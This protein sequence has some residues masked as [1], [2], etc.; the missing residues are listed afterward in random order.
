MDLR[1][2]EIVL[3]RTADEAI[4][5]LVEEAEKLEV[6]QEPALDGQRLVRIVTEAGD[7]E[8]LLDRIERRFGQYEG[9]R[10]VILKVEATLPRPA[11]RKE[12]ERIP[13]KVGRR[14]KRVS[15]EE[16]LASLTPGMRISRRFVAMIVLSAIVAAVGLIEDNV[17]V[18]I[19]AMVIAPLLGPNMALALA[20]TLGDLE[21][22]RR[23]V[24]TNVVGVLIAFAFSLGL[25]LVVT[26]SF[27]TA[28]IHARTAP[29]WTAAVVALAAG[30]AG[31]LAFTA[32]VPASLVGVMVAV[33]LMPPLVVAGL[34]L[35]R[36]EG[37]GALGALELL[38]MNVICV[39]LAGVVTFL[40]QGVRP[41][42]WWKADQARRASRRAM[43][44]WGA[45][46]AALLALL[47][48]SG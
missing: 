9:F 37:A 13:T 48:W 18:I 19:G 2:I 27:D 11:E 34:L 17:A 31:A 8:D 42:S 26:A 7:V 33:A 21:M 43:A 23:A 36:G 5:K 25:G 41:R 1:L 12:D 45:L 39:N 6:W 32:G 22:A 4:R 15:R 46:L 29:Q 20:T 35:G 16:L 44:I 40:V 24:R 28:E 3:P 38:A 47:L 14:A 30:I 10:V